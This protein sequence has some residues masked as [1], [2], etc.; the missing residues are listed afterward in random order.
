MMSSSSAMELA[1]AHPEAAQDQPAA[2][3]GRHPQQKR[4]AGDEEIADQRQHGDAEADRNK[5]TTEPQAG[6][7]VDQ[8]E[9]DRPER[10]HL[11]RPEMAKHRAAQQAEAKEEQ[12]G[13]RHP[14]VEAA[15]GGSGKLEHADRD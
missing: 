8:H 9:I 10:A 7:A 14:A 5:G 4:S 13:D 12:K 15:P 6:D 2:I 1:P 11:A 3:D